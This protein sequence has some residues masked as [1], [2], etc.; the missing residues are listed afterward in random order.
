MKSCLVLLLTLGAS[1]NAQTLGTFAATSSMTTPRDQHTATLL[2]NG[3]VLI[4]GGENSTSY[5]LASAELYDPAITSIPFGVPTTGAF[6]ATGALSSARRLHSATLL[7]DGRV[8][9]TGGY[10]LGG[11]A[12]SSAELYDPSTGTFTATRGTSTVTVGGIATLLKNGKVLIT[13]NTAELYDPVTDSFAPAGSYVG[14]FYAGPFYPDTA[15]SLQDG[16]VLIVGTAGGDCWL[17]HEEVYDPVTGIFKV[18]GEMY[19]YSDGCFG[20]IWAAHAAT[21]LQN[22]K[23]L[24]AGGISDDTGTYTNHAEL[25]DPSTDAI[26]PTAN[27]TLARA[28][29]T[30]TLLTDGNVLV[31]GGQLFFSLID[32]ELYNPTTG[33][34]SATGFMTIARA[35]HSA[36]LLFDGR[37]LTSG[38][39]GGYNY[40]LNSADLYTPQLLAPA[41][42]L[43]SLS[44]DG[45]GQGAIWHSDTGKIATSANPATAGDA[46]SMYTTSL[47]EGDAIPPRVAI[48]GQLAEVL[49]FGAA[50]GYPGY[51]Q[52]NFRVPN[53]VAPGSAATVRLTYLGRPSNAVTIGVQ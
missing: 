30:A 6:S 40:C 7:P 27:M 44:G 1:G 8:L 33:T 16:R 41:P 26:T 46:M 12:V 2:T 13:G 32:A 5:A 45:T 28:G 52:V 34:F 18:V 20:Y 53:A 35:G 24:L 47:F 42:A 48:G 23:V 10:A 25:Y 15:T 11:V 19:P 3:K 29:H 21:L 17:E 36:A 50:P 37:V 39:V 51:S 4:V 14:P 22:G 9:I 31:A 49:Y 38:G 43:F